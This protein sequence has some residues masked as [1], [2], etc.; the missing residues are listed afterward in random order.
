MLKKIFFLATLI[1]GTSIYANEP[2]T[3]VNFT[4]CILESKYGKYEQEQLEIKRK[5]YSTV[6]ED[7]DKKLK[8]V[9]AKL[10]DQEYMDNIAPE[11]EAD[12]KL[13]KKTFSE[14]IGQKQS[15]YY[16]EMQQSQY[17]LMQKIAMIINK[18]AEKLAKEKQ[19][20]MIISKDA[21]FYYRPDLDITTMVV[22]EMDKIFD[23]DMKKA[24]ALKKANEKAEKNVASVPAAVKKD[25]K[26]ATELK[27]DTSKK[28]EL[29]KDATGATK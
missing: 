8:D 16:Q 29:K 27:K 12:L 22:D 9:S 1:L 17:Q 21:C 13:K 15:Q 26:V 20:G 7:L 14:D 28:E 23:E 10:E 18:A 5:Q 2:F 19:F 25:E 3:I 11:A 6:L 4:N 24:A